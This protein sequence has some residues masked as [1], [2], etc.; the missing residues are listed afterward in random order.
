MTR[1][2]TV[3][4]ATLAAVALIAAPLDAEP[5]LHVLAAGSRSGEPDATFVSTSGI[6]H[7]DIGDLR[8]SRYWRKG[9]RN[10]INRSWRRALDTTI[11]QIA[12]EQPDAVFHTGDMVSGRWGIDVDGTGI[13]GP[14]GTL[15]QKRR[16]IKRAA[17]L[18]YGQNKRRWADHG[19]DPYFGVGDHEVGDMPSSG[20]F[21][22]KRLQSRAAPTW[23]NAWARAF[24]DDGDR[25]AWHPPYGQ[26]RKTAYATMI[27]NDVGF[28]SLDPFARRDDGMHARIGTVQMR[29]LDE[30]LRDLRQR[31]ARHLLVQCETP[32]L[33]PNRGSRSSRLVLENGAQL[34][35]LL[36]RRGVD[37]LLTSEFHEVTTRTDGGETPVQVVHGAQLYHATANYLVIRTFHDRIELELKRMTGKKTGRRRFPTVNRP[38]PIDGIRMYRGAQVVGTMTI[39]RDGGLS[40]RSVFLTEGFHCSKPTAG[41]E[42]DAVLRVE[43]Q[44]ARASIG[45]PSTMHLR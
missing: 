14:V 11:G 12:A 26:H 7:H 32:A 21:G 13:F 8:A 37:V 45:A 34:W 39:H 16:A 20:V 31:G 17:A 41:S 15:A 33:G 1:I 29:W 38:R 40:D 10:G 9:M 3:L 35:R 6:P 19:L 43:R 24:T 28:V 36:D 44:Q 30:T 27:G 22:P 5:Q 25:Y 23:R 18:Y 42:C 4:V 2:A